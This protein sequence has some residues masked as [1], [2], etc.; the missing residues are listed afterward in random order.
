MF[1]AGIRI[2]I[3]KIKL[4]RNGNWNHA[5]KPWNR[6]QGLRNI[7]YVQTSDILKGTWNQAGIRTGIGI[8]GLVLESESEWNQLIFYWN[9]NQAFYFFLESESRC[10]RN[11]ASLAA[12]IIPFLYIYRALVKLSNKT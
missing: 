5:F 1:W 10:T 9:R 7:G 2:G 11:R 4:C 6:N 12:E 3:K 8:R